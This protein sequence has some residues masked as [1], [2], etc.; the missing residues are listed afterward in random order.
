VFDIL[1]AQLDDFA[2]VRFADLFAGSGA[3][4]F[5]ALSE[6]AGHVVFV[7]NDPAAADLIRRNARALGVEGRITLLR[8]DATRLGT[9][10]TPVEVAFLD[11]PYGQGLAERALT[12]LVAGRW[13]TADAILLVELGKG[14]PFTP[15]AGLTIEREHIHGAGRLI[16][17]GLVG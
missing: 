3:I 1:W 5:E 12:R 16:R 11:P 9:A 14:D 2:F 7:E 4:G 8:N 15:P 13:L 10:T 6:G 17:L